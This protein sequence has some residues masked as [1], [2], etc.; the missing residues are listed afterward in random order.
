[1]RSLL[2]GRKDPKRAAAAQ[3]LGV[4]DAFANQRIV[5]PEF[6]KVKIEPDELRATID[7]G[8]RA[9]PHDE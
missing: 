9:R 3:R 5:D 6:D 7:A 8:R 2:F 1:M 4:E